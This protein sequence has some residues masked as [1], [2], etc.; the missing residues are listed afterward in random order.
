MTSVKSSYCNLKCK[1]CGEETPL[2]FTSDYVQWE[3]AGDEYQLSNFFHR[4]SGCQRLERS[5][6]DMQPFLLSWG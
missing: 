5:G 4:H 6:P 3:R 1:Y 2:F